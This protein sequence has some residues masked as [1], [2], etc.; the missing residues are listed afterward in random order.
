MNKLLKGNCNLISFTMYAC[1]Y[2]AF[3]RR[4][5]SREQDARELNV[6]NTV[7]FQTILGRVCLE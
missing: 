3:F 6:A 2:L 5:D 7:F 4:P 1:D